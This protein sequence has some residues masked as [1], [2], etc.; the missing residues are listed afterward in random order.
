MA[1]FALVDCNNFYVSCERVFNPRLE[2]VPVAVLSNNDGCVVAR[3]QEVKDLGVQMGAPEFELRGQPRMRG[4]RFFSSNYT[5]YGD[6]SR[7]VMDTLGLLAPALEIYSIDEAFL[8]LTGVPERAEF[9]QRLRRTVRQWTGIPI[10]VGI[11]ATKT[12]AKIANKAGKKDRGAAGVFDLTGLAASR[13]D[14]VLEATAI[15]DVWGVGFAHAPRLRAAGIATARRF[16]DADMGWVRARMG[17]CGYRTLLELRGISC[18]PLELVPPTRKGITSSRSFSELVMS[19]DALCEAVSAYATRA[20][21][22]LRRHKLAAGVLT[23]F[24][25][26]NRFRNDPQYSNGC[27]MPLPCP[28]D[29][30][31][32][33]IGH[34]QAGIARIFREGFK[35]KKAGVMLTELS[36][37]AMAQMPLWDDRDRPRRRLLMRALDSANGRYGAGAVFFAA[38]GI[39]KPWQMRRERLSPCYTTRWDQLITAWAK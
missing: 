19:Q 11:A 34:A 15:E 14:D 37:A 10:A 25:E 22:K 21:A 12:L 3:S 36:P 6:M 33:L 18:L 20:A 32:D 31:A 26:T 2:G 29:D 39:R 5:L 8:D 24:I 28:T 23:V 27:T 16:R 13:L 17:V 7:R 9:G 35:Y 38:E 30:T 1:V 4:V